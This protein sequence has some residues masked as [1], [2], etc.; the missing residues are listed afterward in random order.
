MS[1]P[2]PRWT[3]LE[4]DERRHQILTVARDL[5]GQRGYAVSTEEIART[6]GIRRG[7]LHHYFGTKRELFVAVLES[8]VDALALRPAPAPA[9]V[10][11]EQ[12]V[13]RSVDHWLD[14]VE[15]ETAAWFAA[16]GTEGLGRDAD[17]E[18]LVERAR[19]AT[20]DAMI[21][22]LDIGEPTAALR[23]VLRAYSGL[24]E[25]VTREWLQAHRVSRAQAHAL[26]S[27]SLLAMVREVA[28]AV[29]A[30]TPR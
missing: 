3:R 19:E 17:V 30:A 6:A 21:A 14:F 5:F 10:P 18:R 25:A 9:G 2:A 8:Y 1:E 13:G 29:E 23:T 26:L 15:R 7:L 12:V 20:V 4:P 11:V 28:P 27:T 22:V 16:L 24:A